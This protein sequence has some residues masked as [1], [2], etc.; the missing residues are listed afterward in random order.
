VQIA[1]NPAKDAINLAKHGVSLALAK[2]FDWLTGRVHP[3]R[4]VGG[5]QW[6]LIVL[7]EGVVYAVIFSRRDDV[8]WIISLRHASRNERRAL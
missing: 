4:T 7:F 6:K 8:Y 3:A 2:H 1:F 5:E